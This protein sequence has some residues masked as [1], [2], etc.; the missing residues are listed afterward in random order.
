MFNLSPIY[1]ACKSS[2]NILCENHKISPDTNLQKT[3]KKHQTQNFWRISPFGIAKMEGKWHLVCSSFRLHSQKLWQSHSNSL[4]KWRQS[5][6]LWQSQSNS[7]KKM[8]GTWRL[9]CSS[10]WTQNF[11]KVRTIPWKKRSESDVWSAP[12]SEHKTLTKSEQASEKK[13]D[14]VS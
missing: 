14:L 1:S 5:Q 3:Y 4:K 6:K 12:H 7:L 8:E 13:A 10:F 11:D 2:N 9:V